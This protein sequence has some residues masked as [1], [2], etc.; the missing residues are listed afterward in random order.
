MLK[1]IISLAAFVAVSLFGCNNSG[2]PDIPEP[3]SVPVITIEPDGRQITLS[4]L[5]SASSVDGYRIRFGNDVIAEVGANTTSF[6]DTP[7]SIGTYMI[8]A[9]EGVGESVGKSATLP[10][11]KRTSIRSWSRIYNAF[12]MDDSYNP[13][14]TNFVYHGYSGNYG[15]AS[16]EF[17]SDTIDM[18]F[19]SD[20]NLITPRRIVEEGRWTHGFYTQ[21]YKVS[22]GIP[23]TMLDTLTA[24]PEY[25]PA[26]FSN[27][28]KIGGAGD[29]IV[30]AAFRDNTPDIA[31]D[32]FYAIMVIDSFETTD[33]TNTFMHFQFKTQSE[34]NFRLVK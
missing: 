2:S 8:T 14:Y 28:V 25:D 30:V 17:L 12:R 3:P 11:Y 20:S 18:Y 10:S 6:T 1:K 33:S 22:T 31:N 13:R 21:F 5:R 32:K 26:L 24:I 9:F 34:P 15:E 16:N 23:A 29:V 19:D 4:W 27:S 7:Q